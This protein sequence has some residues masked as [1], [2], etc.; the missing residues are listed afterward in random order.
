MEVLKRK[1]FSKWQA[2][3][4]LSDAVLCQAVREMEQGLIDARLGGMLFKKRVAM[5]G[6]G[7][8]GGYRTMLSA[9][10]GKRYVF[11]CGFAKND[12]ASIT[13]D[14]QKAL[15]FSGRVFLDLPY[16]ALFKALESGVLMEVFCEQAH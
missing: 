16:E 8:G 10:T 12:L 13:L 1:S 5:P 6:Q 15:R 14:E 11:L 4:G 7:K 9:R 2:G 3:E